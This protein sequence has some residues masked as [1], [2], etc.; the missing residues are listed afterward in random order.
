MFFYSQDGDSYFPH[1]PTIHPKQEEIFY[2]DLGFSV[3]AIEEG[4]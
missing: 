2:L 3:Y 1:H 4:I